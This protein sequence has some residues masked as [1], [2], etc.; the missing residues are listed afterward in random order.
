L[1]VK[2]AVEVALLAVGVLI[3]LL[4]CLGLLV[5]RDVFDRLHF[6]SAGGTVGPLL[7]AAA[8]VVEHGL[9]AFGIKALLVTAVI[10]VTGPLMTHAIAKVARVRR[11][12]GLL[13]GEE[14]P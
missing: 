8:V 5:F 9:S 3:Q 11:E 1:A 4:S 13:A 2:E 14:R 12:G 6:L 7:I 10:G